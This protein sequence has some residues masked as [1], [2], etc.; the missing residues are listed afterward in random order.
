[1]LAI[2]FRGGNRMELGPGS[3]NFMPARMVREAWL[4]AGS[5]TFITVDAEWDLSWVEGAPSVADLMK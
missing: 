2:L 3:F 1:M 5:I 4:P